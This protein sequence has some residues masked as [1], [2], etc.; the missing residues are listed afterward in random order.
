MILLPWDCIDYFFEF[1]IKTKQFRTSLW[2][3]RI[4]EECLKLILQT[5]W[6]A[7]IIAIT[8][9]IIDITSVITVVI[10]HFD[11]LKRIIG[12]INSFNFP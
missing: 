4:H 2:K 9:I 10:H 5:T 6:I 7:S 12:A 1:S 3:C 11:A 8:T